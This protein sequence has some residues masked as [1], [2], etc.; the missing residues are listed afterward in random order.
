[1]DNINV[2]LVNGDR[3]INRPIEAAVLDVCYNQALVHFTRTAELSEFVRLG[4]SDGFGLIILV[5]DHLV[6]SNKRHD[7]LI[8]FEEVVSA[9]LAVRRERSTPLMAIS[10]SD[11]NKHALLAAGVEC[12]MKFPF[13]RELLRSEIRQ[14]LKMPEL[15]SENASGQWG[16]AGMW[17]RL[18]RR[19]KS[20]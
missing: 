4:A 14:L 11:E 3:G 7:S 17:L 6:S 20:A 8:P 13:N 16:Q 2:L 19:L 10:A 5:A 15:N 1:M 18:L 9:V 12:A